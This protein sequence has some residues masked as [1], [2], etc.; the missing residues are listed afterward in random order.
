[1]MEMLMLILHLSS[2][3]IAKVPV[4]LAAKKLTCNNAI[5]QVTTL[6]NNGIHFRGKE[7]LSYYC[8]DMKD[9]LVP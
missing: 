8:K 3:E 6:D 4:A 5:V 2:G 7:V 9:T 1:M